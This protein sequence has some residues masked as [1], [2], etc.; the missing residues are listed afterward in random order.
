MKPI[1]H[2]TSPHHG[3][4]AGFC[5]EDSAVLSSL[6]ADERVKTSSDIEAVFQTF[7]D[8]RKTR[9]QWLVASSR[10]IGDCYEWRADGI[11]DD[12]AKIEA[13]INHRNGIIANVDIAAMCDQAVK[14]LHQ[15]MDGSKK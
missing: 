8:V 15:N 2:A 12:F 10:H 3:A 9:S 14:G 4:G 7:D 5:M 6:L 11:G 1:A 13:D